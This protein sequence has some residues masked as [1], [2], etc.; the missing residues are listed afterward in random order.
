MSDL[1]IFLGSSIVGLV[2]AYVIAKN[3]SSLQSIKALYQDEIKNFIA[4]M[5]KLDDWVESGNIPFLELRKHLRA[6]NIRLRSIEK[7]YR[8]VKKIDCSTLPSIIAKYNAF[9]AD[10]TNVNPVNNGQSLQLNPFQIN[11]YTD[12]VEEIKREL[13]NAVINS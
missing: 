4:N 12:A 6:G 8:T 3:L 5:R 2:I 11:K 1:F 7:L 13:L 10:I 9:K